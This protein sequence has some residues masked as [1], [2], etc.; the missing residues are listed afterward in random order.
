M[1]IFEI[2]WHHNYK[3]KLILEMISLANLMMTLV[4]FLWHQTLS[5]QVS[6]K[7]PGFTKEK[8]LRTRATSNGLPVQGGGET[9][10][11]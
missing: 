11:G 9:K 5:T 7:P 8:G 3:T 1:D 2:L 6:R 4:L 10:A